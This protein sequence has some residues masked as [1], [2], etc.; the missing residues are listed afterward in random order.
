MNLLEARLSR[1]SALGL[2]LLAL[3]CPACF[4]Q[5]PLSVGNVI[6]AAA[7]AGSPPFLLTV[8][9]AGFN[10]NDV[11]QFQL[12]VAA[13]VQVTPASIN[14]S[15]IAVTVPAGVLDVTGS[16]AVSVT[17]NVNP[18]SNTVGFNVTIPVI[19]AL[20]PA[21]ATVG[22]AFTL[23]VSGSGFLSYAIGGGAI[24]SPAVY[25]SG[26]ALPTTFVSSGL[27]TAT[28]SSVTTTGL[29]AGLVNVTVLNPN[30][31]AGSGSQVVHFTLLPAP[32]V[33]SVAPNAATAGNPGLN[34]TVTGTNF[35]AGDQV[36]WDGSATG[37][38]TSFVN[39]TTLTAT[40]PGS[41]FT[42][43]VHVV[44]VRSFDGVG[45]A[46]S[47]NFTVSPAPTL[48][49]LNPTFR[50]ST[51]AGF[52]LV[53]TGTNFV[54]GTT[55]QW[56]GAAALVTTYNSATQITGAV[57]ANLVA[58]PGTA[59]ISVVNPDGT[60]VQ[61]ISFP[62]MPMPSVSSLSPSSIVAGNPTF[63][64]TV[65]GSNFTPGSVVQ[66][67]GASLTTTN[68]S[69]QTAPNMPAVYILQARVP[70]ALVSTAGTAA[71]T[72]K[73]ADGAV[74]NAVTFTI[75][76]V[77]KI[78][79]ATLGT[80]ATGPG[81]YFDQILQLSGGLPPYTWTIGGMPPGLSA[82]TTRGEISGFPSQGGNFT[83]TVVLTDSSGQQ[84]AANF[85]LFVTSPPRPH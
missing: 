22:A 80:A 19:S 16:Y 75:V 15:Q 46:T 61:G 37:L 70:A 33:T 54:N 55:V 67:N 6:P 44:T 53:V 23:N 28:V 68:S 30:A 62:I 8:N 45:S 11:V 58:N 59:N 63:G 2:L 78:T 42:A 76:A 29:G 38:V 49:S 7:P 73:T 65:N 50:T 27:L 82:S 17:D 10:A 52:N 83:I 4:G 13:P 9:G 1:T 56:N 3:L 35:V 34:I 79:T 81:Q 66:W 36:V 40:V 74:S 48:T 26:P 51:T 60:V 47:A 84:A 57:P 41:M 31:S 14:F 39:G 25:F 12:G 21:Q 64:M 20:S 71:V 5:A 72:V 77:L 24:V 85:N 32:T 43:A 18:V 69:V